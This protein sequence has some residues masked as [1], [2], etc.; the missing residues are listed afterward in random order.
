MMMNGGLILTRRPGETVYI[1][2][3]ITV[4]LLGIC[5]NQAKLHFSV[6]REIRVDREEIRERKKREAQDETNGNAA[7][8]AHA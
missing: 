1:G 7:P 3:D 6:P 8:E 2:D 5:G 4:T